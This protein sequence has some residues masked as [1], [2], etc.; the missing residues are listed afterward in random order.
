[1]PV[2]EDTKV[3]ESLLRL[4]LTEQRN[5]Q[6][7]LDTIIIMLGPVRR[8][9]ESLRFAIQTAAVVLCAYSAYCA[10]RWLWHI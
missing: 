6:D 10:I 2:S 4:Q 5:V 7:K 3:V 1:M 9:A 8:V